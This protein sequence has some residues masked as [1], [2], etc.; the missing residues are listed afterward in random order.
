MKGKLFVFEGGEGSGKNLQIDML[1]K[2][3]KDEGYDLSDEHLEEPG[4]TPLGNVCRIMLKKVIE[5]P[6]HEPFRNML[7]YMKDQDLTP[8]AQASLFIAS[9]AE[10]YNKKIK[11]EFEKG[12]IILHNRSGLSTVVYQGY[13]QDSSLIPLIRE[14]NDKSV[15]IK[16]NLTFFLDVDVNTGLERTSS[17]DGGNDE[18]RYQSK[19]ND[20]QE[21]VRKGYKKEAERDEDVDVIDANRNPE[22]IHEEIYGIIKKYL[23]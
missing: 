2:R 10:V 23:D 19:G 11:P 8:L 7:D 9:R 14:M 22:E 4:S 3:L 17:R 18:D 6:E 12:K 16:P 5:Y 15:E 20:F 1:K 21:N 13:A